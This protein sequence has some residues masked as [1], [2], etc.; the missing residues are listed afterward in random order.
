MD[1]RSAAPDASAPTDHRAKRRDSAT[2]TI[3]ILTALIVVAVAAPLFLHYTGF[4]PAKELDGLRYP[5]IFKYSFRTTPGLAP[6]HGIDFSQIWLSARKMSAGE[7]VYYPVENK[8]W[9]REWSSTY[10]PFIHWLY[11]PLGRVAFQPAL[12]AHNLAGIA[13]MLLAAGLALR[14]AGCG[15]AFPSVAAAMLAAMYLTPIGLFHLERGQM[16]VFVATSIICIVALFLRGGRGWAIAA[17]LVSTLK[18][19]AWIFVGFYWAVGAALWGLRDRNLWWT[20]GVIL[21]LNLVFLRQVLQWV[22]SFLYVAGNTSYFGPSFTRTMPEGLAFA[23]PFVSVAAVA[24]T[25]AAALARGERWRDA[26]ERRALLRRI[27]FPFA[28]TLAVQT[29]CATPVTH[30]YRLIALLGLLPVLVI[31]CADGE[32][33]GRWLRGG[34][35]AAFVVLMLFALRVK[36]VTAL[37]FVNVAQVL[38]LLSLFFL[39]TTLALAARRGAASTE[40]PG[41]GFPARA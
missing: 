28:A 37:A 36:P 1:A 8:T 12:I 14:S 29:I 16:D 11:A 19:Q 4:R 32:E 34:V 22:D 39:A 25:A 7:T 21:A 6:H 33:I 18:V 2:R 13:A 9:R 20:P 10:H 30:D 3:R 31:W 15:A 23:L 24:V 41:A 38:A 5:R 35:C 26:G 40:P 17:A 27:S